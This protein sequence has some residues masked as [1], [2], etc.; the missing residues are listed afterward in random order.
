MRNE[1][2]IAYQVYVLRPPS[3][4]Q[5]IQPHAISVYSG[6]PWPAEP[7]PV[8]SRLCLEVYRSVAA[9]AFTAPVG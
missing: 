1:F 7:I 8:R 2:K 6:A 5:Q 3:W 9:V 4:R